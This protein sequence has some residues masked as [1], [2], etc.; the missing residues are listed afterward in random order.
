MSATLV[1]SDLCGSVVINNDLWDTRWGK[2]LWVLYLLWVPPLVAYEL[3]HEMAEGE[4]VD[5]GWVLT[6]PLN[7]WLRGH[8]R[9]ALMCSAMNTC[10]VFYCL[11]VL[12]QECWGGKQTRGLSLLLMILLR[13]CLG[14]VTRLPL[15]REIIRCGTDFPPRECSFF[16]LFSGHTSM[17]YLALSDSPF[18]IPLLTLQSLRLLTIRGHYTADIILGLLMVHLVR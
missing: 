4:I 10:L 17:V 2:M 18:T 16:H 7:R 13:A 1:R 6:A 14:S 9:V 8:S 3:V 5:L 12:V 15:S 11:G